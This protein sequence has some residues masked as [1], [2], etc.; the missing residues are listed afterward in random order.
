[1]VGNFDTPAMGTGNLVHNGQTET[2][3]NNVMDICAAFKTL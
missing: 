2:R 1:M 3:P